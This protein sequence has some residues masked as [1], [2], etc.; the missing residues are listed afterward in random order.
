MLVGSHEF[1]VDPNVELAV[2]A[3]DEGEGLDVFPHSGKR[4]ARHPGGPERMTSMLA[5]LDLYPE[6]LF[7]HSLAPCEE[8]NS[9]YLWPVVAVNINWAISGII[10]QIAI[11][12]ERRRD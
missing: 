4:V 11:A 9:S 2:V 5:V 1:A 3:R 7:S 12:T 6:H 10:C 8:V